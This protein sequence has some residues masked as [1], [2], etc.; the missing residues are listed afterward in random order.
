[1]EQATFSVIITHCTSC[2]IP[3]VGF[4]LVLSGLCAYAMTAW[5]LPRSGLK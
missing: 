4:T 1:V 2:Y 5:A 3:A